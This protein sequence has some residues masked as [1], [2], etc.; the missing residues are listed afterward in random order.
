M[1]S[2]KISY[3]TMK[4]EFKT[5]LYFVRNNCL[6]N[7]YEIAAVQFTDSL[8]TNTRYCNAYVR[9]FFTEI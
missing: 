8:I 3:K 9:F 5:K 2:C 7:V 4:L 6:R 1:C